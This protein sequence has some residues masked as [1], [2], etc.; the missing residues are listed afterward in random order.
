M[1][2]FDSCHMK[3]WKMLGAGFLSL[4]AFMAVLP[5]F[6][7]T[8]GCGQ[9]SPPVSNLRTINTAQVTYLSGHNRYASI[10]DLIKE[11]LL[12]P[13]YRKEVSRY[14]YSVHLSGED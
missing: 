4:C 8:C 9:E 7:R 6:F 12:D 14:R 11:G 13:R 2:L 1:P 10:E 5:R 3:R